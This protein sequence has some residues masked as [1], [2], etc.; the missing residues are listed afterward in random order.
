MG[1]TLPTG[2]IAFYSNYDAKLIDFYARGT[3]VLNGL[4][5]KKTNFAGTSAS[6]LVGATSWATIKSVKPSLTYTELYNLISKTSTV[7]KSLK[8]PSGKLIDMNKA[9]NG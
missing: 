3:T 6:V 1:A 9:I 4:N 7:T 2:S 8:V 5:A